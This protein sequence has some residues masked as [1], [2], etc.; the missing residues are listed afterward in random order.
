MKKT[1]ISLLKPVLQDRP[2]L[3]LIG[4]VALLGLAYVIYVGL[5]LSPTELQIATKYTAFGDTQYYRN[6]WYYLFTFIGLAVVIVGCHT[7]IMAKLHARNMR[8]LALAM[9]WF[10]V[11]LLAV[12]FVITH[13]VLGVAYL[14]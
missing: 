7:G 12:L 13:S 9:G 14:S 2:V 6:K 3:L 8:S 1:L 5:A 10:T 11:I 4:L